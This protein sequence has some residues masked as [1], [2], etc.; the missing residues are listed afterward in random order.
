MLQNFI[1]VVGVAD[2]KDFPLIVTTDRYKQFGVEET[3]IIP[4]AK[5]DME[6]ITQ[7]LIE[8]TITNY[9]AIFT[10]TGLKIILDGNLTQKVI[11]VAN[12]PTQSVH[13]A[14]FIKPFCNFITVNLVIP[15]KTSVTQLLQTAG[16]TLDTVVAIPPKVLIENLSI[17]MINTRTISKCSILFSWVGLNT[18]LVPILK[19]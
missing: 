5:P 17:T 19:P 12:E 6:Q 11:Y 15:A 13:S 7:V 16:V 9:R 10:P 8:A 4:A 2:P 1:D 14:E 18:L 3:L